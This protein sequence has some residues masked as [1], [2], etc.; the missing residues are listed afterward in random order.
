M[1]TYLP[2][3]VEM[4]HNNWGVATLRNCETAGA[5][6]STPISHPSAG[7]VARSKT[8]LGHVH[9]PGRLMTGRQRNPAFGDFD[10][11]AIYPEDLLALRTKV[12]ER[13]SESEAFRVIKVWR[14]LWARMPALKIDVQ[15]D[16]DPSFAFSNTAPAPR[17]EI[18]SLTGGNAQPHQI[19]REVDAADRH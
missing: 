14:A 2:L 17:Q 8:Q 6:S 10:P 4:F 18:W 1:E 3:A 12:A 7:K 5:P 9:T 16:A 11:K 15:A 19:A 13:V